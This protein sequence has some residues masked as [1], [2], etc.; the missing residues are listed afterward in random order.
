MRKCDDQAFVSGDGGSSCAEVSLGTRYVAWYCSGNA[1]G[2]LDA[3]TLSPVSAPAG[4]GVAPMAS[5]DALLWFTV[6]PNGR[7]VT[8]FR[9]R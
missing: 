6:I 4:I 7:T 5:D 8:L 3:K 9:P 1:F 2:I